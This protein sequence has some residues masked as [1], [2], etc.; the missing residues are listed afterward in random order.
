MLHVKDIKILSKRRASVTAILA[1]AGEEV[2]CVDR[3]TAWGNPFGIGKHG[4]REEC[5]GW[6]EEWMH[7]P[8]QKLL[9][10][11]MRDQLK[12]K[13]LLCWCDPLPCHAKVIRDI[14]NQ[15]DDWADEFEYALD[16]LD[17]DYIGDTFSRLSRVLLT[18]YQ[19]G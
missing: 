6:Y 8:A 13:H 12:G 14:A 3:T 18:P 19:K 1:G 2:V 10:Q 17:P 16:T 15:D 11:R 7:L 5:I 4:T 9:R